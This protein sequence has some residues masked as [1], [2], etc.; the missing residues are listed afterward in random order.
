[1][2]IDQQDQQP[3]ILLLPLPLRSHLLCHVGIHVTFL[4]TDHIHRRL[5]QRHVLSAHFPALRF[6]SIL[7]GLPPDYPRIVPPKINLV[8]SLRFVTKPLLR[9]LLISLTKKDDKSYDSTRPPSNC[10]ITYG[11][12]RFTIDV[13]EELGIPVMAMPILSACGFWSTSCILD[14][15][16]QGQLHF[17]GEH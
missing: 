16:Q 12:M 10:V 5:H 4:N 6:E 13:A 1:M 2:E 3:H 7:D 11:C 9:D 15:I 8:S 14:L 17:G